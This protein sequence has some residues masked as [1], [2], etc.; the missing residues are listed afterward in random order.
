MNETDIV[1]N[2]TK[3]QVGNT[4]IPANDPVAV[5]LWFI[6]FG[7]IGFVAMMVVMEAVKKW[8]NSMIK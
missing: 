6:M 5:T 4:Y 8:L 1:L 2:L 7:I 3:V